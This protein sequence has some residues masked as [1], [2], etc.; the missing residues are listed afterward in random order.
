MPKLT[1]TIGL[2]ASGK[3]YWSA[4]QAAIVV[5]K[6]TIRT[7]LEKTGWVWSRANEALVEAERDLQILHGLI[8]LR[9][10]VISSDT[11]FAP[12]HETR[13][14]ELASMANASF[15]IKDFRDT[16]LWVCMRR[17]DQRE[18]KAR[19][20]EAAISKMAEDY[21]TRDQMIPGRPSPQLFVD[22]DGVLADFDGFIEKELGIVNNRDNEL[23][24]FW[25]RVRGY[26]GRLYFDM[27]PM[28]YARDL[29]EALKP[30][31]PIIL[32]GCP[33]SI[34]AAGA[35]KREWVAKHIDPDA[36]VITCKS[37]NKS[38][39][40]KPGDIL[41][42]DWAKYRDLWEKSGGIFLLHRDPTE[43][44]KMVRD[45]LTRPVV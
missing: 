33:H 31:S 5:N 10:D 6:D 37:R 1:M 25:D 44:I 22:L 17:N 20:P 42:D 3:S 29:W 8:V 26:R 14:R 4:Q 2:P 32:T 23:P 39:Y 15:E 13:L 38:L 34:E 9:E 7:E 21:L 24:D 12:K 41:L 16:P 40:A 28:S 30:Y 45:V 35:D 18:G 19:V 43:S 27:A 36:R 11:N